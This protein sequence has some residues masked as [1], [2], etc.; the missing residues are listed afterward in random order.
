[1]TQTIV[2]LI[3]LPPPL[4]ACFDNAHG[5]GRKK[6]ARYKTWLELMAY[7]MRVDGPSN[8]GP[9]RV[10]YEYLRP[11]NRKRDVFNLEKATSDLLVAHGIIADDSL[12]V[13]GRV[14]WVDDFPIKRDDIQV[15]IRITPVE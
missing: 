14:K 8:S 2:T 11:D 5:I 6:S 9:I 15:L 12:I 1:M 13:D 3:E 4:S 7:T 10:E